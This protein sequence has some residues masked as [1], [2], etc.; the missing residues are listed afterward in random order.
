MKVIFQSFYP[1]TGL[2]PEPKVDPVIQI[3]N[4]VSCHGKS[5]RMITNVFTLKSCDPIVGCEVHSFEWEKDMLKVS[6]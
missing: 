3:A 5:E 6:Q 4:V 1:D 2:F